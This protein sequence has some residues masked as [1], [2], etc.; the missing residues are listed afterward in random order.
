MLERTAADPARPASGPDGE[1]DGDLDFDWRPE[2]LEREVDHAVRWP[3]VIASLFI[4]VSAALIIRLFVAVPSDTAARLDEYRA[5]AFSFEAA[6]QTVLDAP[7]SDAAAAAEFAD[8]VADLR[9]LVSEPPPRGGGQIAAA[10]QSLTSIADL[11]D[12]L[13][14][15]L[16]LIATYRE[17]ASAILTLPLL[18]TEA[19]PDLLDS[20]ARTLAEYR[21]TASAAAAALG[22]DPVLAGFKERVDEFVEML[23]SW[24]DGY[25]LALRRGET[26]TTT[27]LLIDLRARAN[28]AQGELDT[29]LTALEEAIA[30][31]SLAV[32]TALQQ[33][34]LDG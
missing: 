15:D 29:G 26:D 12:A 16:L 31:Q 20:A 22:E 2:P 4:G 27:A 18:P 34:E 23:P 9:E 6:V 32:R 30:A 21:A 11:S 24:S 10:H 1:T 28:L 19:P 13:A 25:L 5:A 7:R 17:A 14:G 33:A 8:A 3:I